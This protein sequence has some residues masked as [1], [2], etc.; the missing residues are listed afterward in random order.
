MFTHVWCPL[1]IATP[2]KQER[3]LA[4]NACLHVRCLQSQESSRYYGVHSAEDNTRTSPKRKSKSETGT[5]L[6]PWQLSGPLRTCSRVVSHVSLL[7]QRRL[8]RLT[9]VPR[10]P[11]LISTL[12]LRPSLFIPFVA[13]SLTRR[14][15]LPT[16]LLT[17]FDTLF[18]GDLTLI[19]LF[20]LSLLCLPQASLACVLGGRCTLLLV[21][22]VLG[23]LEMRRI[24]AAWAVREHVATAASVA[25]LVGQL[26][27]HVPAHLPAAPPL[28]LECCP[29]ARWQ[30]N[31]TALAPRQNPAVNELTHVV[32]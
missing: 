14:L 24:Q 9:P 8:W 19:T 4:P 15:T 11:L 17:L 6:G 27:H 31:A 28:Q 13:C 3:Q 29:P 30:Q 23:S 22:G 32:V 5:L 16:P 10:S 1:L 7:G 25:H 20:V 18:T 26:P 2:R 21:R 12:A